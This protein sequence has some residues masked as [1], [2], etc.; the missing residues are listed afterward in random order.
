MSYTEK[1]MTIKVI[2]VDGRQNQ[3]RED[4]NQA[5]DFKQLLQQAIG[6]RPKDRAGQEALISQC[7][8]KGVKCP[9][10]AGGKNG[11]IHHLCTLK[12]LDY[13]RKGDS[14]AVSLLNMLCL[15][16]IL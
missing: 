1:Q 12:E 9:N 16:K 15:I 6:L 2:G 4:I 3:N 8:K 14:K 7:G 5:L 13:Q 11:F 10:C